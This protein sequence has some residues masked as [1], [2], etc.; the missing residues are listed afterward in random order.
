VTKLAIGSATM[1]MPLIVAAHAHVKK[2]NQRADLNN[3]D[4]PVVPFLEHVDCNDE[5]DMSQL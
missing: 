3:Q 4:I 2:K 1:P 5:G